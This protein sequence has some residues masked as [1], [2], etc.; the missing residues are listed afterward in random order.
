MP[1]DLP[2]TRRAAAGPPPAEVA[3]RV[4]PMR[5]V[6]TPTWE[7]VEHIRGAFFVLVCA[8]FLFFELFGQLQAAMG[9]RVGGESGVGGA[10]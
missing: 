9:L 6:M 3:I 10:W 5:A 1:A 2:R 8:F 4:P 7:L